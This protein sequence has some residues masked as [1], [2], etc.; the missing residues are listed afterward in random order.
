M[1]R[2]F[3]R[4]VRR[5][6]APD[7]RIYLTVPAGRWLWSDDDVQAG[8]F[9]RYTRATLLGALARAGFLPLFVSKMFSPLPLPL[10]MC[11]SLPS[12][13]GRCQRS[14]GSYAGMHQPRGQTLLNCVLF[15]EQARLAR[16][17]SIPSGTS[18]LAVAEPL[19]SIHD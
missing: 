9:R 2:V 19:L 10:F 15:W 8:H 12:I 3:L 16:G 13:F 1:S 6:L 4:E 18:L 7:G 17:R 5:C 14:A 11:R